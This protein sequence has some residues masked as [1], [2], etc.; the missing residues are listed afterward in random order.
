MKNIDIRVSP[1]PNIMDWGQ[2]SQ[3]RALPRQANEQNGQKLLKKKKQAKKGKNSK[4]PNNRTHVTEGEKQ[5]WRQ[6]GTDSQERVYRNVP[7]KQMQQSFP[8]LPPNLQSKFVSPA[9]T[10][11]R[12]SL[13]ENANRGV[14]SSVYQRRINT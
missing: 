14:E 10:L 1:Q 12:N 2:T 11:F 7:S 4:D 8:L 13:H 3:T 6:N 9:G 5:G